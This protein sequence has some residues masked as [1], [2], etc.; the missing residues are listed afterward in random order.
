MA[1]PRGS[2]VHG[3]AILLLMPYQAMVDALHERVADAGY[4]DVRRSHGI[5]FEHIGRDGAR[6]TDMAEAADMT[7]QAMGYLVD[8]LERRRLVE[9]VADPKDGRAKIVRLTPEGWRVVDVAERALRDTER[10]WA[11]RLGAT[12]MKTL[13]RL[14]IRLND[15]VLGQMV[16]SAGAQSKPAA[17][18]TLRGT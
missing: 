12:D 18:P 7:K 6:I 5:V 15:E 1:E 13:R 8:H 9:R 10:A 14:L 16:A 2:E 3:L 4:P 17:R 11:R